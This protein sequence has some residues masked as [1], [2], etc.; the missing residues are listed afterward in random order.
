MFYIS[1]Y[2]RCLSCGNPMKGIFDRT[3][4]DTCHEC[5]GHPKFRTVR[6]PNGDWYTEP[7]PESE[8]A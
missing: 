8:A 4:R 7:V 5:G 1:H 6:F 3:W 2:I